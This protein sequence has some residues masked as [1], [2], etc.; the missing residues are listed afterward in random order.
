MQAVVQ[1]TSSLIFS[2]ADICLL[3]QSVNFHSNVEIKAE[4]NFTVTSWKKE[5]SGSFLN[6]S[7]AIKVRK[8]I[9]FGLII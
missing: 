4:P 2:T 8:L 9:L 3:Q 6:L 1:V 5:L 7:H